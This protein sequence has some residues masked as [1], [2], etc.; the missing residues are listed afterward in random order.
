MVANRVFRC[1]EC[2]EYVV[3]ASNLPDVASTCNSIP[4][5]DMPCFETI[6]KSDLSQSSFCYDFNSFQSSSSDSS[7][8]IQ[9]VVS[10]S[11][12][13]NPPSSLSTDLSAIPF[14]QVTDVSMT[15]PFFDSY[16]A[17]SYKSTMEIDQND[18]VALLRSEVEQLKDVVQTL[19]QRY[20][21][22]VSFLITLTNTFQNSHT[23]DSGPISSVRSLAQ[24][25]DNMETMVCTDTLRDEV[26][27]MSA[28]LE[29]ATC[30]RDNLEN[31]L[32]GIEDYLPSLVAWAVETTQALDRLKESHKVKKQNKRSTRS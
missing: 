16:D 3:F 7:N 14:P 26:L 8:L 27:S 9:S 13:P 17:S 31:R 21:R 18:E 2:K 22:F 5:F 6:N 28:Q 25:G 32:R 30:E 24:Y 10:S 23:Y 4:T 11:K 29:K 12:F 20:Q 19:Q 15:R 1:L